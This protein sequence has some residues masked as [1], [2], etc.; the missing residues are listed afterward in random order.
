MINLLRGTGR[1]LRLREISKRE[2]KYKGHS[3]GRWCPYYF[4]V[5]Q[6]RIVKINVHTRMY[7]PRLLDKKI[8]RY[9]YVGRYEDYSRYVVDM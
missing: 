1:K 9:S 5:L 6:V 7:I 4:R 8:C 3:V 2:K